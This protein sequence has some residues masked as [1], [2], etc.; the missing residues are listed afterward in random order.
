MEIGPQWSSCLWN[1]PHDKD[2]S[3]SFSLYSLEVTWCSTPFF[4][5]TPVPGEADYPAAGHHSHLVVLQRCHLIRLTKSSISGFSTED[6]GTQTNFL[7]TP[8]CN[9]NVEGPSCEHYLWPWPGLL[10]AFSAS[11]G[12][13]LPLAH[14]FIIISFFSR[15]PKCVACLFCP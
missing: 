7:V 12:T 11:S 9:Y 10:L 4:K 15:V 6:Y 2:L 1:V 8:I 5:Y 14:V 3:A 13:T